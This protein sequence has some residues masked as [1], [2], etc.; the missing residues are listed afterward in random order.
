MIKKLILLVVIV[1][2]TGCG[3]N[4]FPPASSGDTFNS[5]LD[6]AVTVADFKALRE[7]IEIELAKTDLTEARRSE[8]I[9]RDLPSSKCLRGSRTR[10]GS[11]TSISP[12]TLENLSDSPM[13]IT[14][15]VHGKFMNQAYWVLRN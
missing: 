15:M 11:I 8:L 12:T 9:F 3:T 13:R 1:S 4:I 7:S 6:N 10:W 14:C 2:L 5:K